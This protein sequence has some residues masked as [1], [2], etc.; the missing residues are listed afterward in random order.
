MF[1]VKQ[2]VSIDYE[3]EY[4]LTLRT[5]FQTKNVNL[6]KFLLFDCC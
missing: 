6:Y 1:H 5:A 4:R 2:I 3:F